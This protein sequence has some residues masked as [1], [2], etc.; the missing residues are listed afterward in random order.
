MVL[1]KTLDFLFR[2]MPLALAGE[3]RRES[4]QEGLAAPQERLAPHSSRGDVS[5]VAEL[6][7]ADFAE[8]SG[9]R[10][11]NLLRIIR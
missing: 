6:G 3:Q 4:Q 10:S 5:D 1:E 9:N 7:W 8:Q 2:K 11:Y